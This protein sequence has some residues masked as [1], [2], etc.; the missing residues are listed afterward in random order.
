[1]NI[2]E[3]KNFRG[4]KRDAQSVFTIAVSKFF[5][6]EVKTYVRPIEQF[7]KLFAIRILKQP[8]RGVYITDSHILLVGKVFS[9]K[10]PEYFF[11]VSI[12]RNH[13]IRNNNIYNDLESVLTNGLTTAYQN[14]F[15]HSIQLFDDNLIK[16]VIAKYCSSGY[17]EPAKF[18]FLIDYFSRLRTTSFE[19]K[20]FSTGLILTKSSYGYK[21]KSEK[22]K[23]D[24][25]FHSL[26]DVYQIRDQEIK[27]RFW[28][29]ADGKRTFFLGDKL[30]SVNAICTLKDDSNINFVD[31]LTLSNILKGGD[32]LFRVENEKEFS[33]VQSDQS[34]FIY[35]ENSWRYRDYTGLIDLLNT[36]YKIEKTVIERLLF[37]TVF[38]SKKSISCIIWVPD[39]INT[40]QTILKTKNRLFENDINIQEAI[41]TNQIIRFLSSDGA[42]VI[43]KQGYLRNYGCIVNLESA[44][45]QGVKGT[46]ESAAG[47][48]AA[49]GLAIKISQDGTIKVFADSSNEPLV[50]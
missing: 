8:L 15:K 49:N 44:N 25:N 23:R 29:L 31:S 16:K 42:T 7:E 30:L 21:G 2:A 38:C 10:I 43:D 9:G 12:K 19:G 5:S 50:I 37:F 48:L 27:R 13:L 41:Y 3:V 17:Y 11:G 32:V 33:I 28:Y 40:I 35:S 24:I 22:E 36:K 26:L 1:M 6:A 4:F 18:V 14:S 47:L 39:D 45:I 34:E 20:Y 46:G